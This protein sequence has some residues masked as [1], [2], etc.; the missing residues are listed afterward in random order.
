MSNDNL[1]EAISIATLVLVVEDNP[2]VLFN[3]MVSLEANNYTVEIATNGKEA[4]SKL[5][6]MKNKKLPDII[7]SDIMMPEMDGYELYQLLKNDE[8]YKN[9]PLI[10]L[11]ALATPDDIRFAKFLGANDY[12]TK[13]FQEEKLLELITQKLSESQ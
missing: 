5:L 2:D 7:V 10:F 12:I 6:K 13:P 9:I 4:A 3:I 8:Q 1:H 11:S